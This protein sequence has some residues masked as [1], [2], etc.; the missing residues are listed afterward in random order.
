VTPAATKIW[1]LVPGA[2]DTPTG[3]YVYD[4][5]ILSG[6][7]ELG[8]SVEYRALDPSF[9][10]PT[11]PALVAAEGLIASIPDGSVTVI[12]GLAYGAMPALAARHGHRLRIVALVHHPLDRETGLPPSV[13]ESR[14]A[15]ER[16]A[17]AHAHGVIATSA[18]TAAL[19]LDY[20]VSY[21]RVSVV[22]PGVVLGEA[23]PGSSDGLIRLLSVGSLIHRKGYDVLLRAL[24]PLR[25]HAWRLDCVGSP[26]RDLTEARA[27]RALCDRLGLADQVS[28]WG[29]ESDARLAARYRTADLFV[30]ATRF[31]GYGMVFSEA[32]AHGLPIVSTTAGAVPDTVPAGA[33]L[34]VPPEDPVALRAALERLMHD[35]DLRR[36]L[37]AGAW[38]QGHRLPNWA[39]A[40]RGFAEVLKRAASTQLPGQTQLG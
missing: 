17:L 6:L 31:E 3:G 38:A 37:A 14:R 29:T 20:G 2:L 30:L 39:D 8:L 36:R 22:E 16:E 28:F 35:R 19:L 15:G 13:A 40:A 1:F 5:R 24:A 4:R 18:A 7:A 11:A 21:D 32:L 23:A 26:D 27:I 33:G 12:D 25:G 9:P 10:A 34:L